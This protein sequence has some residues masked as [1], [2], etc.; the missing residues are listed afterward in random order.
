MRQYEDG[1][2]Y[3]YPTRIFFEEFAKAD[4]PII[5]GLDVHDPKLFLNNTDLDRAMSVIEGL[6]CHILY[7]Y[8]LVSAAK[9]R[10][11]NM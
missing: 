8:D 11:K 2:R 6:N 7:D 3:A 4:C 9:D 1:M 5:I 10:K